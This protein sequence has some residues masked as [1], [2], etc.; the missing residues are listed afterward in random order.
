MRKIYLKS[1]LK[2]DLITI[3]DC[4]LTS[5]HAGGIAVLWNNGKIHASPILEEP[6]AIHML[7]HDPKK[8]QNST[9]SGIYAPTQ[10]KEKD[11]FREH[12][13]QLNIVFDVPRCLM[14][15]FNKLASPNEK[16]RDKHS[17]TVLRD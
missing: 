5:N 6:R 8:G 7:V 3:Y 11:K 14:G 4:V 9:V 17:L 15:D 2:W 1:F 13:L 10:L 12:L 16:K